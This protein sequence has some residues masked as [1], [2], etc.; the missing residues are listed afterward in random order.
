MT[1]MKKLALAVALT[2]MA[3]GAMAGGPQTL[4]VNNKTQIPYTSALVNGECHGLLQP[5]TK[6]QGQ[7][8]LPWS[9]IQYL[10]G[11]TTGTCNAVI[12]A[13][14]SASCKTQGDQL[15]TATLS[16]DTG[17]VT[18]TPTAG[19]AFTVQYDSTHS[20]TITQSN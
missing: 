5:F 9:V 18:I 2:A 11:A 4:T 17:D 10:C 6:S 3:G 14:N 13:F 7:T 19:H 15:G 8:Q 16:L 20:P 12:Y 1:T